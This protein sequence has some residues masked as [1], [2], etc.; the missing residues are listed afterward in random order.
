MSIVSP[1]EA[2]NE[3]A[4][5]IALSTLARRFAG[6]ILPRDAAEDLAQDV[7]LECLIKLRSGR[8]RIDGLLVAGL[9]RRMVQS[10][11]IDALRRV[12]RRSSRNAEHARELA[13]SARVWMSP[14][15]AIEEE[16]LARCHARTLAD[17]PDVRR[18]AYLL[19]CEERVSCQ[20]AARQLGIPR[21][22]VVAHVAAAQQRF[23][24]ALHAQGLA[25]PAAPRE[26]AR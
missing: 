7:V 25:T 17:L 26:V 24:H 1:T 2:T 10:R 19:V 4:L 20:A 13:E 18:R 14:D 6:R 9:A 16:E 23:Y 11:S 21:F 5:L 12:Q 8:W 22:S 3:E 15:L